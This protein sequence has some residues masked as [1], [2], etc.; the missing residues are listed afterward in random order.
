MP[1]D[2][3]KQRILMAI[4]SL[5]A[6]GGE[7]VGSNLLSKYFNMAVSSATLR[8]EMAALTK[9]GLLEQPHTSAGRVPSAKGYRYYVDNL[10]FMPSGLSAREQGEIDALFTGLDFDPEK[11]AQT[12]ARALAD[13]LGYAVAITTPRAE[14][15]FIAHFEV[16]QVGRFS[17]AVLAV[18]GAGSVLTRV[19]KVE[20]ELTAQTL[21]KVGAA[22]NDNLRFVK[23]PDVTTGYIREVID[24]I[25]VRNSISWPLVSAALT[26]LSEAGKPSFYFEGQHYLLHWPELEPSLRVILELLADSEKAAELFRLKDSRTVVML[27]DEMTS[28]HIPGLCVIERQYLAGSGLAGTIAVLGPTRMP[29]GSVIP[30]LEYFSEQLGKYMSGTSTIR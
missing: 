26:L 13:A 6:T 22:L 8:N 16:L 9:L 19:A 3:R 23:E 1:M 15:T 18:T 12:S 11:L 21:K 10:L 27:G 17:A 30:R 20:T 25:G 14:D 24:K 5:Y 28:P 4:V 2:D 29:F 7:P